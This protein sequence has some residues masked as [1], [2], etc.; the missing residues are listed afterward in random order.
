[1]SMV[2]FINGVLAM[3]MVFVI[4][5]GGIVIRTNISDISVISRNTQGVKLM[6]TA[7]G[8]VVASMAVLDQKD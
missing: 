2:V 5:A 1:M 7:D 8:D 6:D 3:G 4:T